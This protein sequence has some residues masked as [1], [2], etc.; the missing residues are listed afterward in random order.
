M[1]FCLYV[2]CIYGRLQFLTSKFE[3]KYELLT[4]AYVRC[5]CT[6]GSDKSKYLE[7]QVLMPVMEH[8]SIHPLNFTALLCS[9]FVIFNFTYKN[10]Y[11]IRIIAL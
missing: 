7:I 11:I 10:P 1:Y 3:Q 8:N 2:L 5:R 6:I 9:A 4:D